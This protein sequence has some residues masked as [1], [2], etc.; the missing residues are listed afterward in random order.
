MTKRPRR[1]NAARRAATRAALIAAARDLFARHGYADTATPEIVAAAGVTRGA[2]Y[3]HFEDKAAL[4]AGVVAEE[5]SALMRAIEQRA[6][7]APSPLDGLVAGGEAFLNVMNDPG[8]LRILLIDAPSVL[9]PEA[10]EA[11]DD[12]GGRQSLA[13]GL[14]AAIAAGQ[15]GEIDVAATADLLNAIYDRAAL[16]I[17]A[18]QNR[19]PD[20]APDRANARTTYSAAINRLIRGLGARN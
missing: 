15:L 6:L 8:R 4:F 20:R 7:A 19:A 9:G 10:M 14:N 12:A 5:Q 18:S 2:L 11:I 1:T 3:H 16:A 13:E 17:A